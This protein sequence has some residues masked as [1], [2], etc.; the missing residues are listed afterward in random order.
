[1]SL[2]NDALRKK[3][4][5][6]KQ[7]AGSAGTFGKKGGDRRS[8]KW[9]GIRG[10]SIAFLTVMV[11]GSAVHFFFFRDAP[12]PITSMPPAPVIQTEAKA[13]GNDALP[14]PEV[15]PARVAPEVSASRSREEPTLVSQAVSAPT[16]LSERPYFEKNV[17]PERLSGPEGLSRVT[18]ETEKASEKRVTPGF[19]PQAQP[20][21]RPA[22]KSVD[23]AERFYEKAVSCHREGRLPEA[24]ELYHAVLKE[25]AGH[26]AARFNLAA[27]YIQTAAFPEAFSLLEMLRARDPGNPDIL[28]NMAISK[29]GSGDLQQAL[30]LLNAAEEKK[31]PAFELCFHRGVIFSRD[32]QPEEALR[33]YR[34]AEGFNPRHD[35]LILNIALAHDKLQRHEAALRYYLLF[36]AQAAAS[37]S[38]EK[39]VVA[40]RVRVIKSYL[41]GRETVAAG[42][43]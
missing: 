22:E 9:R 29:I 36:L 26:V 31:A 19:S 28:L 24:I 10:F 39:E 37:L 7:P 14:D 1:M 35:R 4:S 40:D 12:A 18:V 34:M 11:V 6:L 2:M 17:K 20:L 25:N 27:A 5:E 15:L 43:R 13:S 30:M 33:W 41:G 42:S 23:P 8:R 3:G 21:E 16:A 38:G 32:D